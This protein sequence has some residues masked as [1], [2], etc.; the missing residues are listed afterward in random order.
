MRKWI[1]A[2]FVFLHCVLLPFILLFICL[3][4]RYFSWKVLLYQIAALHLY[5]FS[6]MMMYLW[7]LFVCCALI[8]LTLYVP[9]IILQC[10]YKPT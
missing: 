10:V 4:V 9:C 7:T 6:L 5:S 2:D 1:A 3:G 8:N